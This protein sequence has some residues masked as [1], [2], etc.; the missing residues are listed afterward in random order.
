M[1]VDWENEGKSDV[2]SEL[3]LDDLE[4]ED[5]SL[6]LADMA[7]REDVLD[8]DWLPPNLRVKHRERRGLQQ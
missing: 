5:L 7:E 8:L 1:R 4:D 3:D 6:K 2:D